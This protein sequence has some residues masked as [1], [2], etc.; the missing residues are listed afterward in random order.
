MKRLKLLAVLLLE[1]LALA[2]CWWLWRWR[3]SCMVCTGLRW[4]PKMACT[5]WN[6]HL[7]GWCVTCAAQ[8]GAG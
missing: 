2:R 8:R 5:D 6:M 7:H 4:L 1:L 3:G